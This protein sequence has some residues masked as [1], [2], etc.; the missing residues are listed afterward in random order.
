[1]HKQRLG[2]ILNISNHLLEHPLRSFPPRFRARVFLCLGH[3]GPVIDDVRMLV[4]GDPPGV[5]V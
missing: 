2:C 1:V 4:A 3:A 5:V